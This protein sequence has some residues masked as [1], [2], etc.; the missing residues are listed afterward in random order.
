MKARL[1]RALTLGDGLFNRA[2]AIERYERSMRV[3]RATSL[4]IMVLVVGTL[5]YWSLTDHLYTLL[6]C[7]YMT[8]ITVSTV[9]FNEV[10]PV[11]ESPQLQL[12]TVGLILFGGGSLL[13]FLS[14]F[15][16]LVIEGDLAYTLWRRKMDKNLATLSDHI[17]VAGA[18][19]SGI[20]VIRE[21]FETDADV[22]VIDFDSERVDQLLAEFGD[23]QRVVAGDAL[24]EAVLRSAGLER[25]RGLIAVLHDDRDNLFLCLQAR[26]INPHLRIVAKVDEAASA[27]MF[28]KVG[29]DALVSPAAIGGRRLASEMLTPH[30][31]SF[32]DAL[33]APG[34]QVQLT[35]L[36]VDSRS[37]VAGLTLGDASEHPSMA[38]I[39]CRVV[40]LRVR[41]D[42]PFDY[43][44]GRN[45]VL[46]AGGSV[47]AVGNAEELR[48]LRLVLQPAS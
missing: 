2:I 27:A 28:S 43:E 21:L 19:R 45:A 7:L 22:V 24:E 35:E 15:T 16:A 20:H 37:P 6:T 40:G 17:V 30:L 10:L 13:Y 8:V 3:V 36:R 33:M 47:V 12:F 25:A 29:V 11:S 23:T 41:L 34:Q 1:P 42:A 5:G 32:A 39:H 26:H 4:V 48:S 38:S 18:G 46:T 44:P 14:S 9:G 31:A